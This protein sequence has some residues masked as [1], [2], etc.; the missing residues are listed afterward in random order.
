MKAAGWVRIFG[1]FL[2]LFPAQAI[3][4]YSY[5][6]IHPP[7]ATFARAAWV[8]GQGDVAGTAASLGS[9]A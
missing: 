2:S 1:A 7:G 3:P 4:S 9:S 5:V 6:D 8:N